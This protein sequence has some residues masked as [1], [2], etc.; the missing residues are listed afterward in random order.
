MEPLTLLEVDD[1]GFV[2]TLEAGATA[3]DDAI[4]ALG[5]EPNGY[6]WEGIVTQLVEHDAPELAD[7][8]DSDPEAGAYVAISEDRDVL[9]RLGALLARVANDEERLRELVATAKEEGFTFDD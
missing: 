5:H 1:G 6:F 9:E 4:V 2:L 7:R 8:F 3:V